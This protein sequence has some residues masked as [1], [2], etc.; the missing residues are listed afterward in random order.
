M[1]N[2]AIIAINWSEIKN[3]SVLKYNASDD[4]ML[5]K[6]DNDHAMYMEG[7]EIQMVVSIGT[8]ESPYG[9]YQYFKRHEE[10]WCPIT[11]TLWKVQ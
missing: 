1:K 9:T 4:I 7:E 3:G 2:P 11:T 10:D 8:Y 5:V 6:L